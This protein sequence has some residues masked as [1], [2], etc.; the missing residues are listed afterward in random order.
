MAKISAL[1][2]GSQPLF[3]T[4]P[5]ESLFDFTE[6]LIGQREFGAVVLDQ[7]KGLAGVITEHDI[8]RET[9]NKNAHLKELCVAD[10]MTETVV[11][12]QQDT[13]LAEALALMGKYRIR[14]LLVQD[15]EDIL[16]FVS[17]QA[18]LRKIH[19]DEQLEIN[20]LRDLAGAH[21]ISGAA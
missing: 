7:N 11:A 17:I 1:L 5:D 15:V 16:G 10:A 13:S 18:I 21:Q 19:D 6:R 12:C 8:V 2:K 3:F 20:V 9:F 4:T 14:H